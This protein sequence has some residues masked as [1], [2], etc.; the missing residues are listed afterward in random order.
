ML[1]FYFFFGICIC[2][3]RILQIQ[4]KVRRDECFLFTNRS[5][6]MNTYL[7]GEQHYMP[8]LG[9]SFLAS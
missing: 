5:S 2:S 7:G 9:L 4:V 1:F 6:F 8:Q 3:S